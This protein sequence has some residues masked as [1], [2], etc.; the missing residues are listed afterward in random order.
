MLGRPVPCCGP[1]PPGL[2]CDLQE[3][4]ALLVVLD[5]RE[6]PATCR[7]PTPCLWSRTSG[8][9]LRPAGGQRLACGPGPPGLS[10]YLQEA[11][12]L[13]V[14]LDLRDCPATCRRP[15]PCCGPLGVS[16]PAY[17]VKASTGTAGMPGGNMDFEG[18]DIT[19]DDFIAEHCEGESEIARFYAGKRLFVTGSTGFCG[20]ILLEKIIRSCPDVEKIYV[21]MRPKKG[22]SLEER[23]KAQF[24]GPVFERLRVTRPGFQLKV[25]PL[26]GDCSQP[27]LGLSDESVEKL[28]ETQVIFHVAAT[29]RFD[30]KMRL[31]TAINVQ[32]N[33]DL[34]R[35]ARTMPDLKA[36]V[37]V[38]TAYSFPQRKL[39][40]E[41]FYEPDVSPD[42][43]LNI[44]NNMD[45][46]MLEAITPQLITTWPNTYAFT[47]AVGEAAIREHSHGLPVVMV[48]PSIVISTAREPIAGWINNVY[49]PT[50]VVMGAGVG[51]LKVLHCDGELR[52]DMVPVDMVIN[53]IIAAAWDM[54]LS[55]EN[56][57]NEEAKVEESEHEADPAV[58][59][60]VSSPDSPI[61]WGGFMELCAKG[62]H[63]PSVRCI[64]Y[65]DF[66]VVRNIHLY[67]VYIMLMHLLPALLVDTG[68]RLVG[69]KPF[70]W[71]AYKKIH[72]FSAVIAHFATNEWTF[73]NDNV[74]K[75]WDKMT[76]VD[77]KIFEF[78]CKNLRWE[79]YFTT[80]M[81]GLRVYLLEDPLDTLP[82][83]K[84]KY[85]KLK[86]IH[87]TI[88]TCA[89]LLLCWLLLQFLRFIFL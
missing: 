44:V 59:N 65:Y 33:I 11:N 88:K 10:C 55:K 85:R 75:L 73:K 77:R 3:A 68:C 54:G 66:R 51:L 72:K 9:V 57:Q 83:G 38:S 67:N 61:T 84:V 15:T 20:S 41:V 60:F 35:L 17:K 30:E 12:A 87:Y 36:F 23:F 39:V 71:D 8:T 2:S 49:G 7:R 45:D 78:N 28:K 70:L 14:V 5:L 43:L 19:I 63:I 42:R 34:L 69:K 1:G 76:P 89:I 24:D 46:A 58:L 48:R 32:S 62:V 37:H 6:C 22:K 25:Y 50:G 31:A 81:K 4:D 80:Y 16:C 56:Q 47:K 86:I 27:R 18:N 64:W 53:N 40:E 29:V 82:Q 21:L 79:Q 26:E 52:A 74:H 13:L